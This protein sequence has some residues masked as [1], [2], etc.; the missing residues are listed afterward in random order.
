MHYTLKGLS[1][2]VLSTLL[3]FSVSARTVD[4]N[5]A[6][7]TGK[8]FLISAGAAG[9]SASS[10]LTLAYTATGLVSGATVNDYYV[11]NVTGAKAFVMVSADDRIIPILAY[12]NESAFNA[13]HLSPETKFWI[14]GYKN[15]ITAAIANDIAAKSGT[16]LQ[17]EELKSGTTHSSARTTATTAVTPLVTTTWDQ[18]G[19]GSVAYNE[20]C[21]YDAVNAGTS[22]TGC[23]ATAMAQVMKY[24]NWPT[25]GCGSHAYYDAY[26]S[27]EG[28][29]T[30]TWDTADFANTAYNWSAMPLS[31]SNAA[32]ATLMYHAGVSVNMSYSANESG[33]YVLALETGGVNCAEYALKTYFHYKPTLR[34]IAR[35]G[36][37]YGSYLYYGGIGG[38]IDSIAQ[39]SWISMLQTELSAGRP[40]LYS[41]SGADGG[42][43][44]VCDGWETS[45]SKF[46]FNWGWSGESN[47]YFTVDNLAPPA[48]G[49]GGGSGNFNTDQ[50]VIMGI[51]PDSFPS[52]PGK[53]ELADH[54]NTTASSPMPYG[55]PLSITTRITNTGTT[56]FTGSFTAYVYDTAGIIVD[57]IA[58][59]T[60]QTIAAGATSPAL[61]FSC[62]GVY[63]AIP[64]SYH[65][66]RVLY[67]RAG[68][69]GGYIPVANHDSMI[70]YTILD[71]LNDTDIVL[72]DSLTV[73]S[74]V[75]APG[76]TLTAST[77]LWNIGSA[78][79]SGTI[80]AVLINTSTGTSYPVQSHTSQSIHVNAIKNESF[81]TTL[82]VP[83]GIYALE[84]AH[85]YAGT[86]AFHT[87]GSDYYA[88]PVLLYIGVP[89]PTV[90]ATPADTTVVSSSVIPVS[91]VATDVY[92]FPNP[93][94]DALNILMQG[95][96]A[97]NV[98]ITDMQGR[99]VKS[100]EG[101]NQM[102]IVLSVA[103]LAAG[104]YIVQVQT[105]EGVVTK[106]IVISK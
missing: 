19:G 75:L 21:P 62:T 100:I 20:Y 92:V 55:S 9:V 96:A 78:N 3:G 68:F 101:N 44:W 104:N 35:Y 86:G 64:V 102:H 66:I 72:Y 50:G 10:E 98:R 71:V 94:N 70:N 8:N 43:C 40:M 33:S 54:L 38:N 53:L 60:G 41:G 7:L 13:S 45:G 83:N 28:S 15:Q 99:A 31:S 47:G 84:V 57:T 46:H 26:S 76:S 34:G 87:T 49:T 65:S 61:T 4:Q 30:N 97:L 79:F 105:N 24:W 48:L 67:S 14:D 95:A 80:K 90:V 89:V 42:H 11:F 2:L 91:V 22:V 39:A 85:Q 69:T 12:S 51:Q 16:A 93:A 32:V 73:G 81:T 5:T 29:G 82:S 74:H 1:A 63:G 58:T 17:W 88:N 59:L 18:D 25:A 23:V 103:D 27:S 36:E 37:Y 77:D 56:A 6:M 106:K 52:N